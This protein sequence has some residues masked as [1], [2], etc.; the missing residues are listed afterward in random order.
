MRGALRTRAR[1]GTAW[2]GAVPEHGRRG[3][4]GGRALE[5]RASPPALLRRGAGRG[6]RVL[7]GGT[8]RPRAAL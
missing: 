6:A 3:A 4:A 1:I 7:R 5:A 2:A 8:P